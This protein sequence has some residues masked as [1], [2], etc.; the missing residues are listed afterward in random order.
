MPMKLFWGWT[1]AVGAVAYCAGVFWS[2]PLGARRLYGPVTAKLCK[3]AKGARAAE[4]ELSSGPTLTE[5]ALG[6]KLEPKAIAS[7]T[8]LAGIRDLLDRRSSQ[9][10]SVYALVAWTATRARDGQN[11]HLRGHWAN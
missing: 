2:D 5:G 3:S 8:T 6:K 11:A 9:E 1:L 10:F 4:M 7:T